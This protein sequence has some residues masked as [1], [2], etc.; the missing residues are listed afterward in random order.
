M[1][2][3]AREPSEIDWGRLVRSPGFWRPVTLGALFILLFLPQIVYL[4]TVVW[5]E[6]RHSHGFLIPVV[7]LGFLYLNREEI[8]GVKRSP[9]NGGMVLVS[10]GILFWV[11]AQ[12]VRFN[13]LAHLSM[14]LVIAGMV[15]F[16][17]GWRFLRAVSFPVFYLVFAFPMPKRLDDL[18]IAQPLQRVSSIISERVIELCGIPAFRQGNVIDVP[19]LQLLV[20][21]ACS[22]LHSVYSLAALGTAF[23]FLT[24]RRI[25]E[26][27]V[28]ILST[29]PI[30]V[31]ANVIRV[32]L[33]GVLATAVSPMVAEGF[34]HEVSGI[35]VFLLGLGMLLLWAWI[36]RLWFPPAEVGVDDA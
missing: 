35:L 3:A 11:Y 13:A 32:S 22:G 1:A 30:A 5:E 14:L 29:V 20:E 15:A 31:A 17:A 28:L 9:S 19:G 25:W 34:F 2:D 12:G 27:V 36:L 23:V 24:E 21:E 26:R 10:L 4:V 16:S 33:T 6:D 8:F 18:Y 7:S